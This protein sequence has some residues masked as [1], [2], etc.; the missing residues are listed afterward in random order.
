MCVYDIV[1]NMSN[2]PDSLGG[3]NILSKDEE[4]FNDMT[5]EAGIYD[6]DIG[7]GL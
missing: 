1:E 4:Y 7:F 5:Q 3:N 2:R 6:R